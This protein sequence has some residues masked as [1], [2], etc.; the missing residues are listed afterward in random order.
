[1]AS[2]GVGGQTPNGNGK[3]LLNG[4]LNSN[5]LNAS[6]KPTEAIAE[7]EGENEQEAEDGRLKGIQGLI[8]NSKAQMASQ[9]KNVNDI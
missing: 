2:D 5:N 1:V 4:L 7:V 6:H 3:N 8:K 9:G